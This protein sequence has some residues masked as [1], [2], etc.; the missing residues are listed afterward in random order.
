MSINE[1]KQRIEQIIPAFFR[2]I[3]SKMRSMYNDNKSE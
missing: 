2:K 1:L 3:L